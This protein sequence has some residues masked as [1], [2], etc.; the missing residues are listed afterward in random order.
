MRFCAA[1][2]AGYG[3][4]RGRV[5]HAHQGESLPES[6]GPDC[7]Q[8]WISPRTQLQ[9]AHSAGSHLP[10]PFLLRLL[11]SLLQGRLNA[12][13]TRPSGRAPTD[14]HERA[15]HV[16]GIFFLFSS[17][18]CSCKRLCSERFSRSPFSARWY[19]LFSSSPPFSYIRCARRTAACFLSSAG[20]DPLTV[21]KDC[22]AQRMEEWSSSHSSTMKSLLLFLFA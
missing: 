13:P 5:A 22:R 11:S 12:P 15:S 9:T 1:G 2:G 6:H 18:H 21:I 10:R 8:A 20:Q 16:Y 17:Q 4:R 3:I 7:I 19:S 14:S